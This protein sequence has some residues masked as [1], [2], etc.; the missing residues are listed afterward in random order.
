M[1]SK[2][3]FAILTFIIIVI[4]IIVSDSLMAAVPVISLLTSFLII[5]SH[6]DRAGKKSIALDKTP[7]DTINLVD[8]ADDK[9][10]GGE[11]STYGAEYELHKSFIGVSAAEP[12]WKRVG[13]TDETLGDIDNA[14][15]IDSQTASLCR[16]RSRDRSA[17]EGAVVKNA[18]YYR[19]HYND[20][21]DS[22]ESRTWWSRYED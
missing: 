16:H 2:L 12:E 18:D 10:T 22:A 1:L 9:W 17:I 13:D 3:D 14:A 19:D 11:T 6:F 7:A 8:D 5:N 15:D 21:F 20:E 4:V